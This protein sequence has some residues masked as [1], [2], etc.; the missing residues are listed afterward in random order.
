[1]H[2]LKSAPLPEERR[3]NI[4]ART[5]PRKYLTKEMNPRITRGLIKRRLAILKRKISK[6]YL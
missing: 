3:I 1:M 4:H 2:G 5:D 6:R